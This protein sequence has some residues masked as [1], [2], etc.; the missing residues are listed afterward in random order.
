MKITITHDTKEGGST[1]A[2]ML[3][4][5]LEK[6]NNVE[7]NGEDESFGSFIKKNL[8]NIQDKNIK[9][10]LQHCRRKM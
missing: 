6:N 4:K 5:S 2:S 7:V 10:R 8:K 3:Y 1:I 9:I